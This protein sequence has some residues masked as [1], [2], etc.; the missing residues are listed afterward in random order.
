MNYENVVTSSF[1]D[2]GSVESILQM[3][4]DCTG[5]VFCDDDHEHIITG[6]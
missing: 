4:C 2:E 6:T 1:F 3:K 5:S